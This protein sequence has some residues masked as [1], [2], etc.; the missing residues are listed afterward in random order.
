MRCEQTQAALENF[1]QDLSSLGLRQRG[2]KKGSSSSTVV[3]EKMQQ[4]SAAPADAYKYT[5][6]VGDSLSSVALKHGMPVALL[7]RWNKLLSPTL[8]PGQE[9]WVRPAPPPTREQIRSDAIRKLMKLAA[10]SLPEASFYLD[11]YGGGC[12]VDAALAASTTDAAYSTLAVAA[13]AAKSD[14][15]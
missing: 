2:G 3:E 6:G 15:G 4:K 9:L 1:P 12:D 11:E 7:K 13:A 5:V 8:Y 14:G 10:C